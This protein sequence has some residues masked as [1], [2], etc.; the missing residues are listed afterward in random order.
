MQTF[1]VKRSLK[2]GPHAKKFFSFLFDLDNQSESWVRN[3]QLRIS[4]VPWNIYELCTK[5]FISEHLQI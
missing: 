5:V 4:S 3:I 2:H 1:F